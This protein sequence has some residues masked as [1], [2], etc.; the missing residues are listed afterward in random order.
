MK[1]YKIII[2]LCLLANITFAQNTD[3]KAENLGIVSELVYLKLTSENLAIRIVNDTLISEQDKIKFVNLYN[4]TKVITDQII[5]QLISDCRRKNRLKYLRKLD[6]LFV[7]KTISQVEESDFKN[8][9]LKGYVKNLK[10]ANI[11]YFKLIAFK[12][13][14]KPNENPL[15]NI[16]LKGFFPAAMSMEELTGVLSFITGTIKD[17]RESKEKKVEKLTNILNDLRLSPLQD[18]A[19]GEKKEAEKKDEKK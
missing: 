19:K 6:K 3:N 18:L 13:T 7:S 8:D 5:V 17:I 2:V 1:H 9:K 12:T 14:D 16:G 4:D 15:L 10:K 11:V